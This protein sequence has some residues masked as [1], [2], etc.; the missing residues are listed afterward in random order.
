MAIATYTDLISAVRD[1]VKRS[2]IQSD[3]PN[4]IY[5]CEQELNT[6]LHRREMTELAYT[7]TVAGQA[8]Y[9]LPLDFG[10]AVALHVETTPIR[11]LDPS[12]WNRINV[13][14]VSQGT[15][16]VW[17]LTNNEFILGPTPD[18]AYRITLNYYRTIPNLTGSN[19]TNWLLTNYPKIYLYGALSEA[20]NSLIDE[21]RA[22]NWQRAYQQSVRI[23]IQDQI[24]ERG[25]GGGPVLRADDLPFGIQSSFNIN[26][27]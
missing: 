9:G 17:S 7:T 4:W 14:Y 20:A 22:A 13:L 19:D 25:L 18:S 26:T 21:P 27:G 11:V 16:D 5:L 12:D 2:D 10:E 1:T 24:R 3:I 6:I 23:L 8:T 15:P